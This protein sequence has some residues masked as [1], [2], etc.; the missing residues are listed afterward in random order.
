[1][2]CKY[3]YRTIYSR[4]IEHLYNEKQLQ[5]LYEG[6]REGLDISWYIDPK[7]SDEQ[8]SIIRAGLNEGLNVSV[9]ADYTI[10][11]EKMKELF[12]SLSVRNY[13]LRSKERLLKVLYG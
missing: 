3:K 9:Y 10:G 4:I 2:N 13:K 7:F 5:E 6:L 11:V 1:M 12:E 8:M